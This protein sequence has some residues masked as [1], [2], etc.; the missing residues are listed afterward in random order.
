MRETWVWS[1][2]WE[3]TLEKGMVTH[4]IVLA[5]RIPLNRGAWHAALHGVA[6]SWTQTERLSTAQ[7]NKH[8]LLFNNYTLACNN[9]CTVRL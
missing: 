4:S 5:W 7:H 9:S 2:G 1:L 3:D 8:I 6:K